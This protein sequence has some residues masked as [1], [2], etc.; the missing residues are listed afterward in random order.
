[1]EPKDRIYDET[2]KKF[3]YYSDGILYFSKRAE[4][5]FFFILTLI[6]LGLGFLGKL[7]VF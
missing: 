6:M 7:G 4:R 5:V 2:N 1:M 3:F